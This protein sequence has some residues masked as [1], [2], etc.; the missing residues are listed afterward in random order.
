MLG[1]KP[2]VEEL[3]N[4]GE[5]MVMGKRQEN[6]TLYLEK[7][8]YVHKCLAEEENRILKEIS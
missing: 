4:L 7:E 8:G 6:Q 5:K 3:V 2:V 1:G